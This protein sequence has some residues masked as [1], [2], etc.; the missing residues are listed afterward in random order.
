MATIKKKIGLLCTASSEDAKRIENKKE[1]NQ[2]KQEEGKGFLVIPELS[3]VL[4]GLVV[5]HLK[6]KV[7]KEG[8]EG[9]RSFSCVFL[10]LCQKSRSCQQK[11]EEDG[12]ER[13][14]ESWINWGNQ[15]FLTEGG[16]GKCWGRQRDLEN[17][18]DI[19]FFCLSPPNK[20]LLPGA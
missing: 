10:A 18:E 17:D 5:L 13:K 1:R 2:N 6:T 8:K 16:Q 15:R 3:I 14:N 4:L 9:G 19:F 12:D 7:G 11:T 20:S